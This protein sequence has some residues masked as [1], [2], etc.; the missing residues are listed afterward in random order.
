MSPKIGEEVT[1]MPEERSHKT[2]TNRIATKFGTTPQAEGPD[3]KTSRV[4]VEVETP[5]TIPEAIGQLRGYRG[6]VYIAGTNQEAV[7]KALDATANT[8]VGVMDNQGNIV[9]RS[10]RK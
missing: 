8:T 2:T 6:P 9:K 4:T 1:V 5:A 10:T 7:K 3:V